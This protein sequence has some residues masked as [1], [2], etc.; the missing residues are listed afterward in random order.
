MKYKWIVMQELEEAHTATPYKIVDTE[1]RAEELCLQAEEE[2][3]GFIFWTY[4]CEEE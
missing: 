4:L 2:N 1:E 3:P